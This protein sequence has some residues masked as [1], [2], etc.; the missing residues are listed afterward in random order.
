M[1]NLILIT[2]SLFTLFFIS[3]CEKKSSE[4]LTSVSTDNTLEVTV[5]AS[6]MMSL[7]PWVVVIAVKQVGSDKQIAE[8]TQEIMADEISAKNVTFNWNNNTSCLVSITQADGTITKIPVNV[9]L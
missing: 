1:K 2:A 6:R 7:D 4:M 3:A 9:Q 8:V 5:Q